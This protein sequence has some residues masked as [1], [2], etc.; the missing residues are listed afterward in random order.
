MTI[1][2]TNNSLFLQV[3]ELETTRTVAERKLREHSGNVV[4]ALTELIR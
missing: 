3:N 4:E 2:L 1:P